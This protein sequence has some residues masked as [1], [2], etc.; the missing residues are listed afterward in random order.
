VLLAAGGLALPVLLGGLVLR[1]SG[2]LAVGVALLG[3]QQA[4]R[5]ELGP[6]RLDS[7][8]PLVAGVLLLVA[9]LAWWSVEARVP[10]SSEPWLAGRRL[11]T[12]LMCCVGAS[13]VS[14]VVAVAGGAQLGGGFGLEL[15]GIAAATAAVAVVAYVARSRSAVD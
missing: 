2:A 3:A 5:L 13:A 7:W 4:L 6:D 8:I 10:A 14:G 9:E 12:I 15:V 11:V 1:W